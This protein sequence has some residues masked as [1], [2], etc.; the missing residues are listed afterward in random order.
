MGR[1][2]SRVLTAEGS[3]GGCHQE[4]EVLEGIRIPERYQK[5]VLSAEA[6]P[7]PG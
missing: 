6:L 4:L 2:G 1:A 5:P 3:D 7:S